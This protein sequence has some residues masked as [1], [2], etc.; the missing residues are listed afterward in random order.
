MR[1]DDAFPSKYIKC[2]DLQGRAAPVKIRDVQFEMIGGDSGDRKAVLYFVGK[3]KGLVLNK[4]NANVISDMYGYETDDWVGKPI[5][6]FP[7]KTD[8]AGKRVDAIRVREVS[9]PPMQAARDQHAPSNYHAPLPPDD[10][11]PPNARARAEQGGAAPV[12]DDEIPF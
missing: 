12:F 5:E 8:Y 4:T 7:T 6:L 3:E 1:I 10:K 9:A 11:F 2:S